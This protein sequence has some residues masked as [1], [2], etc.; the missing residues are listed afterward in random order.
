M[1][2]LKQP[3]RKAF[4]SARCFDIPMT[5][6]ERM[7]KLLAPT[8]IGEEA[9]LFIQKPQAKKTRVSLKPIRVKDPKTGETKFGA[10]ISIKIDL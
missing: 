5:Q 8:H 4:S 10:E 2:N 3:Q 9:A 7:A 6:E 1:R